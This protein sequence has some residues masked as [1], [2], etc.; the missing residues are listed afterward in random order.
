MAGG[1]TEG[2]CLVILLAKAHD[3]DVLILALVTVASVDLISI[4]TELLKNLV[5]YKAIA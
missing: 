4:Y 5:L 3:N 1:E 2:F